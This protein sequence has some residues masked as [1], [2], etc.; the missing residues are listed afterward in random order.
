MKELRDILDILWNE[1]LS[2]SNSEQDAVH[3]VQ[4]LG[5]QGVRGFLPKTF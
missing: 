2:I 1:C 3:L 5:Q 4:Q